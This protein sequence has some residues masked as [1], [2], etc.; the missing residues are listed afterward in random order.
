MTKS[1]SNLTKSPAGKRLQAYAQ[2]TFSSVSPKNLPSRKSSNIC[3]WRKEPGL[4]KDPDEIKLYKGRTN[5]F[6]DGEVSFLEGKLRQ[7][8]CTKS[9]LMSETTEG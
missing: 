4:E 6:H 8:E 5:L 9:N 1:P 2:M 7:I 3:D